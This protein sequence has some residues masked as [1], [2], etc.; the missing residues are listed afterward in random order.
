MTNVSIRG[1]Y[2]SKKNQAFATNCLPPNN[3]KGK[4]EELAL[5][6]DH[7]GL[8]YIQL[9]IGLNIPS[10]KI[11]LYNNSPK[12]NKTITMVTITDYI[13][14]IDVKIIYKL[15]T[16]SL[17]SVKIFQ[18]YPFHASRVYNLERELG[19]GEAPLVS[20]RAK[21]ITL[22]RPINREKKNKTN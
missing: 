21:N 11:L 17:L 5:K 12:A 9:V 19:D 6:N 15:L 4:L 8:I 20:S 3:K 16:N 14:V 1:A 22:F 10:K 7:L 18:R 13:I 2:C